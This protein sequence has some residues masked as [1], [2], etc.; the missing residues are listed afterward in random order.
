MDPSYDL[1]ELSLR[2]R[3]K[4]A[5]R[6]VENRVVRLSIEPLDVVWVDI[7]LVFEVGVRN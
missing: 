2:N 3:E 7:V 5:L 1:L 4:T 6:D